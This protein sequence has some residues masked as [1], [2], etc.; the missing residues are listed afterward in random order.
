MSIKKKRIII[1]S[2]I[3]VSLITA[4]LCA[5]FLLRRSS[6]A[7]D[8]TGVYTTSVAAITGMD[9]GAASRFSGIVEP[10][11]TLKIQKDADRTVKEI[12]VEAGDTVKKGDP[13][14]AY[15]TEETQLKLSEAQ[16]EVERLA[17]D[18]TSLNDQIEYLEAEKAKAPS[19]EAFSYTTQIL[20][21]QNDIKRAEYNKK[22][23]EMEIEQIRKNLENASVTSEID[24]IVKSVNDGTSTDIMYGVET[25]N[26][27]MTILSANAYRI[28]GKINEQNMAMISVGQ[29]VIVHSRTDTDLTWPGTV[30]EIDTD[31]PVS[32][33]NVYYSSSDTSSLSSSYYFY[34]DLE[35]EA[36]L[37]LGQHVF[38]EPDMGQNDQREGLWLNSGYIV[39][40]G[41]DAYV[42]AASSRDT[43]EKRTVT[44]GEYDAGL[45]EY[46]IT[47]G[48]TTD[49]FIAFPDAS[50][51]EGTP[52]VKNADAAL[53]QDSGFSD[54][55]G[56]DTGEVTE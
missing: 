34:V 51:E 41:N 8:D 29:P 40:D 9:T 46:Q 31:N 33:S 27:F 2:C 1:T 20:T 49:D 54:M 4:G 56:A 30:T 12:F 10:Q 24:G 28:K 19:S 15:D 37:M 11:E 44:L 6:G 13:L 53:A 55:G 18:I 7:S 25:D 42:W 32:N 22:S 43:L 21:A 23:K 48:L 16:L 26:A 52:C 47:D 5:F 17:G 3:V 39:I 45:D 14:F 38:M 35:G 36:G 50:C